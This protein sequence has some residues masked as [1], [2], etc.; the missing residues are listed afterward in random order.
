MRTR[1]TENAEP[2]ANKGPSERSRR[3]FYSRRMSEE[4][5]GKLDA[6]SRTWRARRE[7]RGYVDGRSR[8]E[9]FATYGE[10]G[11]S[12]DAHWLIDGSDERLL[13]IEDDAEF[14]QLCCSFRS[15]D[16]HRDLW[17]E[18][19]CRQADPH[20]AFEDALRIVD[21]SAPDG[22]RYVPR[23]IVG[24]YTRAFTAI[25]RGSEL[26]EGELA[27]GS[28]VLWLSNRLAV[29]HG[30]GETVSVIVEMS[31]RHENDAAAEIFRIFGDDVTIDDLDEVAD[32]AAVVAL[33]R[34][35]SSRLVADDGTTGD[36]E[37]E[38]TRTR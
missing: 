25:V 28:D 16:E 30:N 7:L 18:R 6:D 23:V 32:H 37:G 36:D 27:I 2:G 24:R 10:Y 20:R 5:S 29:A 1:Y 19:L 34:G 11:E 14:D 15:H 12:L 8:L 3:E 17:E 4:T 9:Q 31:Q 33:F 22:W 26:I 35:D 13:A 21:S 38:T